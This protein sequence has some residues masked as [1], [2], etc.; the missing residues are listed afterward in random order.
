MDNSFHQ[1]ISQLPHWFSTIAESVPKEVQCRITEL[2]L[3]TN[4]PVFWC[5]GQ[6]RSIYDAHTLTAAEMQDLYSALCRGSAHCYQQDIAQGFLTLEG[7]HRA[8]LCGTALWRNGQS[9]GLRDITSMNI[10]FAKAVKGCARTLYQRLGDCSFLLAGAPGTGKTTLLRDYVRIL[11]GGDGG[12]CQFAAVIDERS[13]LSG[14]DLGYTVHILK[15]L[16]KV[17]A[18]QQALRTLAPQYLICD[19]IGSSDEAQLLSE[20]LNSGCRFIGTIHAENWDDLRKKAQFQPF[21]KQNALDAVVFLEGQGK[22]REIKEV[23]PDA[24]DRLYERFSLCGA[25]GSWA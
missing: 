25:A 24:S 3:F 4:Q 14:F 12:T 8:G 16:P 9:A 22:I 17:Q 20:S 5:C 11:C 23:S 10:R 15:G 13:E 1:V 2:R 19:E 21:L 18:I 7:G 6:V